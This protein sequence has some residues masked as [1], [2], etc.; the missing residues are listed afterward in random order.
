MGFVP[1]YEDAYFTNPMMPFT[2]KSAMHYQL[3]NPIDYLQPFA[4]GDVLD[5]TG[6]SFDFA[7]FQSPISVQH[8]EQAAPRDHSTKQVGSNREEDAETPSPEAEQAQDGISLGAKAFRNSI[9]QFNPIQGNEWKS[10][11]AQL[12]QSP[13][14]IDPGSVE[15]IDAS[16]VPKLITLNSTIRNKMIS[17]MLSLSDN[18]VESSASFLSWFPSTGFLTLLINKFLANHI[19]EID[20]YIHVPTFNPNEQPAELLLGMISCAALTSS[21]AP[22][23]EFGTLL[24]EAHRDLNRRMVKLTSAF[25]F[26]AD[27]GTLESQR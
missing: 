19:R 7:D 26:P 1:T 11:I 21:H 2:D 5:F 17:L 13:P 15:K 24:H 10:H 20:T 25:G 4:I 6:Q 22:L 14:S 23:H 27:N 12:S 8:E 3:T 18:S 9:W 16:A